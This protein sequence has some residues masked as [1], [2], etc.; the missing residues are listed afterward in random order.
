MY[1][2]LFYGRFS[3]QSL[4]QANLCIVGRLDFTGFWLVYFSEHSQD[5]TLL[6]HHV[7]LY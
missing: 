1:Q 3:K 7:I 5:V 6:L 2:Y 4:R